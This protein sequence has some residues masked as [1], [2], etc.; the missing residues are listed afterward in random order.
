MTVYVFPYDQKTRRSILS[1]GCSEPCYLGSSLWEV[2]FNWE[3]TVDQEGKV[4]EFEF[5]LE[6]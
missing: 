5:S 3:G 1:N 4:Q 6:H 2:S